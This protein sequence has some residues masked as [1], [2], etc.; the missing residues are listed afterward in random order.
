M[1]PAMP[2]TRDGGSQTAS[3]PPLRLLALSAEKP[4]FKHPRPQLP[5]QLGV[6]FLE[7]VEIH[8]FAVGVSFKRAA[9]TGK[10]AAEL[11]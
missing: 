6:R 9:K 10:E 8:G 2:I 5:A 11:A 7:R 1:V 3:T 4:Q